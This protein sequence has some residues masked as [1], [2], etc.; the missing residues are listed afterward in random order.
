MSFVRKRTNESLQR[1]L[2]S[3]VAATTVLAFAGPAAMAQDDVETIPEVEEEASVQQT[4]TV[5][6]SRIPSDPNLIS[7]V[8]VQSVDENAIKLSGEFNLAD[9]VNDIPALVSSTTAEQSDTGANALNLRGLGAER[10]LT[11]VNG[12]RHVA[13]FRGTQAVD[14]GTIPRSLVERVEV[15]TGGASAVYGAD[16]VTGVVNFVLKDDFE[17]LQLDLR[18]GVSGEGDAENFSFDLLAGQNFDN[19]KGNVVF[20]LSY[21]DDSAITYG[22]RDWSRDNGIAS[23]EPRAN[24]AALTDPNAPPRAV[25]ND[26]RFWLTSQEGSIAPTFGG[27]NVNYVDIN[28][29]GT[30]DCQESAGGRAAFLAGCWL[31][32]PDGS[33]RVNQDGIVL[34]GLWGIGGDGGA[35]SFNRDTLYPETDKAVVN[36][37]ANYD[38]DPSFSV[39]FEAK[40]VNAESTTFAEQD[41]FYDTLFIAAD[42]PFIPA[43]LNPVVAQTGGLLLTQDPLDFSDD[44][45]FTYERETLRFVAGFEWEPAEGH[46]VEG[47]INRGQFTRRDEYTGLYLDRVFAAIDTVQDANGNVV[48]RSDLNPNAAYEIDYFTAGNGYADGGFSSDRYYSFTPGDG[49]CAPLNP[50][51]TYSTS[52]AARDFVTSDLKDE[53]KL[54]QTVI[55]LIS[56]GQFDVMD[57]VLDGPIGYAAGLEY[58]DERSESTL[59]PITLGILPPTTSFTPGA[60]VSQIDPFLFSYTSIDNSQQFNTSGGYDVYDAFAEIRLPILRDRPF[61]KELTVDGAVRLASYST[62]GEATTWKVGGSWAPID[63]ITFRGTISEAVRAPN[64]SELFDPR[65]PIEVSA[66]ADPCDPGNVNAGTASRLPN[67]IAD[68][69]AAGVPLNQIV[70][71]SGNYIYVNPLTGR[72]SGVSGGNPDLDVETAET[73]TIGAVFAPRFIEGFT[74]TVDYWDVSIED[75]ISA[76][77]AGDILDGCL[78]SAN[79]PSLEFCGLYTRRADGGLNGLETGQINFAQV[80]ASG[81]D[82]SASYSF[83]YGE[84]TFGATLVGSYQEKLDRF[85]NPA[86][87]EDV[88]PEIEELFFPELSGNLNLSWA[89]GPL[90]VGFQTQYISRQAVDEVEDI[91]GLNGNQAL[92]GNAGFFDEAYIFDANAS[93]EFNDQFT[94]YGGVNNI[95]GKDPYSTQTAWPVGPRGRFF[96]LG[97]T[98]TR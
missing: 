57:F 59:D 11:L 3:G 68:L 95:A 19:D 17:G 35:I 81:V 38:L 89:R 15:T 98:Y 82:F 30:P 94:V 58:R 37:N 66:T 41:T 61:A 1:V 25:I 69:Q 65:L 50:F 78:D 32:N 31:T 5:T 84:N 92:Y 70:D 97:L 28:G 14:I 7:S 72:F 27:R 51:G 8:P 29:N 21:E 18:G 40:W 23:V 85:F 9:V 46:I 24:P 96:F 34:N 88:N 12:R 75:A 86:D 79:Y 10:T 90:N 64:V 2:L 6:G 43:Q 73:Y 52:Q 60:Q 74:L 26:P 44:N 22:D 45:P 33:I 63:D 54:Q 13:G 91:L 83:D 76:V 39:F 56:T 71:G 20:A 87:P 47:S 49:S 48:C 80:E 42:N 55:S 53:L 16:A 93:Y 4:I 77:A 62:L 36:L 67:C